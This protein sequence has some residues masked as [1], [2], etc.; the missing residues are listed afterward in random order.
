MSEHSTHALVRALLNEPYIRNR[1]QYTYKTKLVSDDRH[2]H[3]AI[4]VNTQ[5]HVFVLV[6][7]I[8]LYIINIYC[9]CDLVII[10]LLC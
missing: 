4:C 8:K 7:N 2:T 10:T 5:Y 3:I 1:M 9:K 6:I